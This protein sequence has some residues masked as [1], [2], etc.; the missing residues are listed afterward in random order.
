MLAAKFFDD[1]Y[2]KNKYYAQVGGVPSVEINS[3]ELE[4][5]FSINFSLHVKPED[6]AK[7]EF[8]LRKHVVTCSGC[9]CGAY[10]CVDSTSRACNPHSRDMFG[11]GGAGSFLQAACRLWWSL[12]SPCPVL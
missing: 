10:T 7:Y 5:L 3:L 6:F 12:C 9:D 1:Q 2:F 8:E 4:F 11:D